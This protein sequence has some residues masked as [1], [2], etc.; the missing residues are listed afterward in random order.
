MERSRKELSVKN[1]V[2]CHIHADVVSR[3][4]LRIIS[5]LDRTASDTRLISGS[6]VSR[7]TL[8]DGVFSQP[9]VA[10]F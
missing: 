1:H 10:M 7:L 6:D 5:Q 3:A 2:S 9:D 4:D 8:D